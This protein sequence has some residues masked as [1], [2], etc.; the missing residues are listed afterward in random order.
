[1]TADRRPDERQTIERDSLD[2]GQP[3]PVVFELIAGPFSCASLQVD[4][5]DGNVGF[6]RQ[7]ELAQENGVA[8]EHGNPL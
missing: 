5:T 3:A 4:R 6:R 8:I 2:V 7:L 1:M